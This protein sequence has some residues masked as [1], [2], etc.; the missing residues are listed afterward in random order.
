MGGGSQPIM[1]TRTSAMLAQAAYTFGGSAGTEDERE[2]NTNREVAS[3]GF[4]LVRSRSDRQMSVF[5]R[6]T[7]DGKKHVHIAHKGTQPTTVS[8][9]R[10]LI[11][12]A[13][14]ATGNSSWDSQFN[15]RLR[16]S[17]NAVREMAPEVVTMSGHSL[18]GATV[19]D[20]LTRSKL[21][22]N[23]VDQADT[24][25]AGATP[26][27]TNMKTSGLEKEER[28]KLWD[29]LT[30]HRMKHD[31]VSKGLLYNNSIGDVRTYKLANDDTSTEQNLGKDQIKKM[32]TAEKALFAHHIDHFADRENLEVKSVKG[33]RPQK[34][35]LPS[36]FGKA[37]E[38]AK[39]EQE[40]NKRQKTAG[41]ALTA[42]EADA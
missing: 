16:R 24:F 35:M 11:S 36:K 33:R 1:D 39:E 4:K 3:T 9:A 41:P 38:K 32:G 10:D 21:L 7:P 8:G 34:S 29:S 27:R 22:R 15:E 5:E 12:D 19:G 31:L 17:E 25:D 37:V 28:D 26:G 23:S 14:I 42:E 13:R 2:E 6:T 30:H 40:A 18:G 20:S